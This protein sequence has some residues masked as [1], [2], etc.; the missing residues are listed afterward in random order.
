MTYKYNKKKYFITV[1]ITSVFII[2]LLI[3]AVI[4]NLYSFG[5]NIYTFIILASCYE[6]FNIYIAGVK[7]LEIVLD[8]NSLILRGFHKEDIYEIQDLKYMMTKE[9][10][11]KKFYLRINNYSLFKGRYWIDTKSYENNEDMYM[12]I[13]EL[14]RFVCPNQLKYNHRNRKVKENQ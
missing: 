2:F 10:A 1:T 4:K 9:L 11:N 3:Y 5:V 12:K 14:E 8:S 6:L 7:P 13:M